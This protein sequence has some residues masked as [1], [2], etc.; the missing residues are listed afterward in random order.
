MRFVQLFDCANDHEKER[1]DE[2]ISTI[3]TI[4]FK[5]R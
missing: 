5:G 3:L 1:L 2:L 4:I